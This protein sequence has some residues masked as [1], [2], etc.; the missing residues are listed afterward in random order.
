MYFVV[1]VV[2][3]VL[4]AACFVFPNGSFCIVS[5]F[6]FVLLAVYA[7]LFIVYGMFVV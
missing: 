5:G 6:Y 1:L 2:R 4:I 7:I 3:V